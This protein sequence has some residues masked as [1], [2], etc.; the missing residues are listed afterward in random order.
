MT[1]AITRRLTHVSVLGHVTMG[2]VILVCAILS[3][4]GSQS[5]GRMAPSSVTGDEPIITTY[6]V[7]ESIFPNPERGFYKYMNLHELDPEIGALREAEGIT[8]VWGRIHMAA[9]REEEF[10]PADFLAHVERGFQIARDQGM[11][12]IVRGSYGSRGPGGD[13]TTYADPAEA[14]IRNHITQLA[15]IFAAHADVIALFEAGFIGPWGEW[16][17]TELANDPDRSRSFVHFLLEQTPMDRMIVVRYPLLK[18]QVFAAADGGFEQVSS[19]NA[20]S[21]EA[22]ARV[23]HHNDCL[24]SS[25]DDVGTY[26][27]GGMDREREVTYLAQETLHTVFGGES[28]A[29]YTLND[30]ARAI[31]ELEMLHATYLNSG[32]H[33]DVL[34]KWTQQG[35]MD[36]VQ[37]RLGARIILHESRIS[38]RAQA[39]GGLRVRLILENAGFAALYNARH[40]D[41]VLT[42]DATGQD[43]RLPTGMDP[44]LWKPRERHQLWLVLQ[45]PADVPPGSYT[46]HLHLADAAP[47]LREDPRYA[48][49][50]ASSGVWDEMTGLNRLAA[51]IIVE[52]AP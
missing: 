32:W 38:N 41:I 15:P 36:E 18:Q 1:T 42:N 20:Y 52:A 5:S 2:C 34:A 35:C 31:D 7:D 28:C 45:L 8:L 11:K 40:V 19:T 50:V 46:A 22:V 6:E 33:P 14:I 29:D 47:A 24:L 44:R 26:D 43:V 21:G 10:L 16:H 4:C 27:R 51:G 39:G 49:R 17:S 37:Q 12:V 13:Y 23:G 48:I 3:G 25:E 30:C 9:Y